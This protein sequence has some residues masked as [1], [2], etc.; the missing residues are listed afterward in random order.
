MAVTMKK[1]GSKRRRFALMSEMNLT[2]MIDVMLV[3]LVILM[4][5]APLLNVG[6]K[7]NLPSA[8]APSVTSNDTPIIVTMDSK[9]HVFI[10]DVEVGDDTLT[11]KLRAITKES[12]EKTK[13]F[14]RGDQALPYGRIMKTMGRISDAGFKKVIL[15]TE[16]PKKLEQKS[17]VSQAR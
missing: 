10:G 14:V 15:V 16:L 17:N 9:G 6:V 3:L 13:I 11:E 4:A 5:T 2:P 12:M 8:N 7:V 1:S